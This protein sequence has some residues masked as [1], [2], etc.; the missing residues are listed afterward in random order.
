MDIDCSII[1][2]THN[3]R[4]E[5]LS[6]VLASLKLQTLPFAN[7][8]L[9]LIDN[10]SNDALKNT[11]DLSWHP[12]ARHIREE[13]LGL[14]PARLRGI[15]E[16]RGQ[17][18]IYVDD[19]GVLAPNYLETAFSIL[20]SRP[21]LGVIGAG[22]LQP[23]FEK[24]PAPKFQRLLHFLA[25]RS[26]TRAIWSNR[27]DDYDTI[28]FGA[29]LCVRRNVSL[30]YVDLLAKLNAN[31]CLD[32]RGAE[33]NCGGDNLFSFAA[34][35]SDLGFGLFPELKIRHLIP[36][37]RLRETYFLRLLEAHGFSHVVIGY[38][39]NTSDGRPA[40]AL[41]SLRRL[42]SVARNGVFDLRLELA[43][44][45]GRRR[46]WRYI[47]ARALTPLPFDA[48]SRNPTFIPISAAT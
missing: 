17:F 31:E 33:L 36:A 48:I 8:E 40:T 29:G 46:A 44:Q 25:I 13:E 14:T 1:I 19:D 11:I 21:W 4:R 15:R 5:Y 35:F 2:C 16:S 20:Q 38:L 37:A 45:R 26:V 10:A 3:P 28:P 43:A 41:G 47:S 7:W 6:R 42:L 23:E 24:A 9:L 27:P 39:L 18:L 34:A 30:R 32:R 12:N 22:E